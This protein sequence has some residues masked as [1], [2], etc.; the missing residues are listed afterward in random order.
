MEKEDRYRLCKGLEGV[1][2]F[3]VQRT[4]GSLKRLSPLRSGDLIS[5]FLGLFLNFSCISGSHPHC[6]PPYSQ[7]HNVLLPLEM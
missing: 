6:L 4:G 2:A 1:E 3:V 7:Y 5:S